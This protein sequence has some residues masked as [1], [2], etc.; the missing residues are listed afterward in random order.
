ME[1]NKIDIRLTL[2]DQATKGLQGTQAKMQSFS[3]KF[4]QNWLSITAGVTAAIFAIKKA[5]DL[6][7][8]GARAEQ[9]EASFRT[10]ARSF[11][12]DADSIIRSLKEVSGATIN[13]S[14]VAGS[15]SVLLSQGIGLNELN[16][17][18]K[19]ARA[20]ARLTGSS[21]EES[22]NQISTAISGGFLV[23]VKRAFGLNVELSKAYEDFAQK[24][25]KTKEEVA[26]YYKAQA[27]ANNVI[28]AGAVLTNNLNLKQKTNLETI[29]SLTAWWTSL[30]ETAGQAI[31]A[32]IQAVGVLVNVLRAGLGEAVAKISDSFSFLTEKIIVATRFYGELIDKI[33]G[34]NDPL[35]GVSMRL[36]E[37]VQLSRDFSTGMRDGADD[38]ASAALDIVDIM[39]NQVDPSVRR[40]SQSAEEIAP[41]VTED[42]KRIATQTKVMTSTMEAGFTNALSSLIRG[43]GS[44]KEVFQELG[45]TMVKAVVDFVAQQIIAATIGKVIRAG[46]TA[47]L[48]AMGAT[49]AAAWAPAAAMTSL[50]SFGS[51]AGPAAAGIASVAALTQSLAIPKMAEGG[52]ISA[53]PGGRLILAGEAGSDE[54]IIPLNKSGAFGDINIFIQGG[55]NPAGASVNEMAEQLGFAF[56]REIRTARS[57]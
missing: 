22:F 10:M 25:G 34:L 41:K 51:N 21:V 39:T 48:S 35:E 43:V 24:I 49:V 30:K 33:P 52:I 1:K 23:T 44:A 5:F 12:E 40:V 45:T 31:L 56:E 20:G 13:F 53:T 3:D 2:N 14:N 6:A 38:F 16:E 50:A 8:L 57:I 28:Q 47:L 42:M 26:K 9:I 46:E 36:E 18:M 54:A 7:K 55:I 32:I 29:Q 37:M 4:K 27:L 17:L 11:G 19:V 15:A